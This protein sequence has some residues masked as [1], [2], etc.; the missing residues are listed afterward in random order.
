M[1]EREINMPACWPDGT[2]RST[3]NAF[4]AAYFVRGAVQPTRMPAKR[5]PKQQPIT[6]RGSRLLDVKGRETVSLA[7]KGNH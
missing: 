7:P 3:N 6:L 5:G 2:A 1:F 4:A